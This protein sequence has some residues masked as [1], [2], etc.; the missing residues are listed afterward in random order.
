MTGQAKPIERIM[1][2]DVGSL[3]DAELLSMII[4]PLH[5][6]S[7][8]LTAASRILKSFNGFRGVS[9]AG[10]SRI[11]RIAGIGYKGAAR[12]AAA[13]ELGKR[14]REEG[15]YRDRLKL[16]TPDDVGH[17]FMPRMKGYDREVFVCAF[18]DCK[19]RL[20]A[21]KE[22]A[23]GTPA[24]ASPSIRSVITEA[25]DLRAVSI[26]CMHNHPSGDP[27]PST[28]DRCFTDDLARAA[29]TVELQLLDHVVFGGDMFYS[30]KAK[31]LM[32]CKKM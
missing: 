2:G 27:E 11:K 15:L 12:L 32:G 3:A 26:I 8:V 18:L 14:F 28:E 22:I 17:I 23:R 25:L 5:S 20:I 6:G 21:L 13:F 29:R 4:G 9:L 30:F 24:S 1:T 19:T 7:D 10:P 31:G 16:R